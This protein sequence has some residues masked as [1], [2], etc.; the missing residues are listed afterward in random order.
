MT[1][2][3]STLLIQTIFFFLAITFMS[4]F[5]S[6][7][8]LTS[9]DATFNPDYLRGIA[10]EFSFDKVMLRLAASLLYVL[11]RNRRFFMKG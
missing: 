9:N 4:F 2:K 8:H 7:I 5:A 1:S 3:I 10:S 6:A 11:Y